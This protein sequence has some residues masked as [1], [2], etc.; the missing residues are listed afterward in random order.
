MT[1]TK[2]IALDL[3][4]TLLNSK[5]ELTEANRAA[6]ERAAAKGIEI[7]PC[8]GRFYG[9]MPE[10]IRSLPFVHYV[11]TINGAQIY[12]VRRQDV[13]HEALI[14][15]AQA[16]DIMRYLDTKPVI[17]DCYMDNWGWM[18][19]SQQ[20]KGPEFAPDAHYLSM[21]MNL[22][23][24]VPELKEHIASVGHDIQKIQFFTLDED[25]RQ[26]CFREL[27]HLFPETS[28]S[29]SV[30]RNVEINNAHA[31]KGEALLALA[32]TLGIPR[33]GTMA[34]GDALND[35]SMVRAAGIGVVMDNGLPEMKAEADYVTLSC[36]ED[37]VAA[38]LRHFNLD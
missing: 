30:A 1:D 31:N 15:L 23:K 14:P 3:D 4:G 21:L 26:F 7:V 8:T 11:I 35:L 29:A 17:Y 36:D 18:T 2:I 24:P 9:A 37:G 5:K 16:L 38:A 6:L 33:E 28:V 32:D 22:R 34:F 19:A 25:F 20:A 27:E 12:D 13:L 10:V